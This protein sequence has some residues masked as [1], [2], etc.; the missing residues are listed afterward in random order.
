[1]VSMD[2]LLIL[3]VV[4]GALLAFALVLYIFSRILQRREP[5]ASFARLRTRQKL[6]FFRLLMTDPR[7][8]RFVKV[9]PFLLAAYLAMPF[10]IIPDFIP[11]LG[12]VDD[13]AVA[14]GT[15]ALIIRLTPRTVI[16]DLLRQ[17]GEADG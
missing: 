11:V 4:A 7:V 10:D 15:L 8:P 17:L 3:V 1:M 6:R 9:L 14:L 12:Y 13:V 16:D 5:Y 2:T